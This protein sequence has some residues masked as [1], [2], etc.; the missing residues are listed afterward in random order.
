MTW[1]HRLPQT[2]H[3]QQS[4]QQ[5]SWNCSPG[6]FACMGFLNCAQLVKLLIILS[7]YW[8][9]SVFPRFTH[10]CQ[11]TSHRYFISLTTDHPGLLSRRPSS[12]RLLLGRWSHCPVHHQV[13]SVMLKVEYHISLVLGMTWR[14]RLDL[15]GSCQER[16][17]WVPPQNNY[18]IIRITHSEQ[19]VKA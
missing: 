13:H 5:T 7:T 2:N 18:M 8:G 10:S 1:K 3:T 9:W 15:R 6:K 19:W 14:Q 12:R 4:D 11:V 17:L 16:I